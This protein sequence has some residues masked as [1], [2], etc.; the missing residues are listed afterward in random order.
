MPKTCGAHGLVAALAREGVEVVFGLPGVQVMSAFDGFM[1][2]GSPRR[3]TVRHE[4]ATT[5]MAYGYA[6]TTGKVGVGLV[7]PGPGALNAAA[8][9][10]T[11]YSAS[12]P[13][14]LV[15][16]QLVSSGLGQEKGAL[17]EVSNQLQCFQP[18]TKWSHLVSRPADVPA[19]VR[20][21][22]H[23]AT[24]GRPR[25]V[26]LEVPWD[27][28]DR[29]EE[30]ELL[31]PG[32]PERMEP[33]EGDVR[34]A[35]QMLSAAKRPLIWAGGGVIGAGAW[36]ELTALAVAL[37]AP[38]VTTPEGKGAIREDHPLALGSAFSS[39]APTRLSPAYDILPKADVV[40][41]VGSR[42]NFSADSAL[43][44]RKEQKLVQVDADREEL[45]RNW[46]LTLGIQG[47]AR[48]TLT[49][50]LRSV[51][52]SA[53][54][55]AWTT[56]EL[57]AARAAARHR[58]QE[59]APLQLQIIDTIRAELSDDAIVVPDVTNIAYY[60]HVAFPV[61]APRS[62][63]TS[64]YFV[65][66]G[67]A[68]PTALGAKVGNPDKQVV[69]IC[70]DGGFMFNVQELAT[71]VQEGINV[72]TLVFNDSA[73]GATL[74]D[75]HVRY[76][77]HVVGTR[78]HNPDFAR[79]AEAFGAQGVKLKGPEG[80]AEAMRSALASNRPTVIDI[81]MPTLPAPFHSTLRRRM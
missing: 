67:Y 13:V 65:S 15:S 6:R 32:P 27:V 20:E 69:A 2:P 76:D 36:A 3:V 21:A 73:F 47:D 52:G 48:L 5:Y 33:T 51:Q 79:L 57:D 53:G 80:L 31:E 63:V 75:Q 25:A 30:M 49:A 4:Q 26:E 18:I 17:H 34:Q 64:S 71:A 62:W 16:G 55:S 74:Y 12:T 77:D 9:L 40:L 44:F 68:F 60:A 56:A 22:V 11:A 58:L 14:I 37:N 43:A 1:R 78:L 54:A 19:A 24:S 66:L 61:L 70:G 41:A 10:G 28:M 35:A 46:P 59:A 7:V 50:L 29:E 23:Q 39:T 42:L 8:G 38:V 45:G 72:V 81:P